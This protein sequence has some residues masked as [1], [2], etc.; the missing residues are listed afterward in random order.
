MNW[1]L[2]WSGLCEGKIHSGLKRNHFN[3]DSCVRRMS[4]FPDD[5]FYLFSPSLYKS[6]H[7]P[8]PSAWSTFQPIFA[9]TYKVREIV[10]DNSNTASSWRG[11]VRLRVVDVTQV[12]LRLTHPVTSELTFLPALRLVEEVLLPLV[13]RSSGNGVLPCSVRSAPKW[14]AICGVCVS[15]SHLLYSYT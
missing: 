6:S 14:C 8:K 3:P 4:R 12:S 11:W 9:E 7:C 15:S 5:W 10:V 13:A 1:S 2:Y